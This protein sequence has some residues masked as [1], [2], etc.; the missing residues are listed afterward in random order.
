LATV[1]FPQNQVRIVHRLPEN[2][3][4][5][6]EIVGISSSLAL[7]DGRCYNGLTRNLTASKTAVRPTTTV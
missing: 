2:P 4:R 7:F 1:E 3:F 6:L 5:Y